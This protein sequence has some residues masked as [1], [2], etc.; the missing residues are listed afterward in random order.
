MQ[1]R[2]A[3]L[4]VAKA[5]AIVAVLLGHVGGAPDVVGSLCYSF[6]M[7]LFF[8]LSGYFLKPAV[9]CDAA[10][11]RKSARALLVPYAVTAGIVIVERL[12][13]GVLRGDVVGG[14]HDAATMVVA[15]LYGSGD[16]V[17][18][19]L[20]DWVV[21]IGAIWFLLAL[22][23]GRLF[24]AAAQG[25][26]AP[27][28]IVVM[29]FAASFLMVDESLWLPFGIQTGM[30]AVL[31]LYVGQRVRELGLDAP[32]AI[33]PVLWLAMLLVWGYCILIGGNIFMVNNSFDDG[34]IDVI[35]AICGSM[36]VIV[37]ARRLETALPR[38][39]AP[40][41]AIGANTLPIFCMHLVEMQCVNWDWVLTHVESAGLP[42]PLWLWWFVLR[43]AIVAAMVGALWLMP[44]ALSG[45]YFRSCRLPQATT[46]VEGR[47]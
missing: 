42:G 37:A 3:Y 40:L 1:K 15:A 5:I 12:L 20:S 41:A 38:V 2:I 22:F 33:S 6:H 4:D 24:L 7:P 28:V 39:A 25:T 32:G 34:L 14:L 36:C 8:I 23:W 29:L 44:R 27:A 46:G 18:S 11:V 10:F 43:C 31:F 19:V 9:R 26:R 16:F 45:V 35:G 17:P 21:P 30:G 47:R 13:V